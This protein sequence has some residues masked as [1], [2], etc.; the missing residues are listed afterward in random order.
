MW[1]LILRV[2][3]FV[4]IVLFVLA[5]IVYPAFKSNVPFF[6]MFR[7]RRAEK[8]Y[9]KQLDELDNEAMENAVL[10]SIEQRQDN[11]Q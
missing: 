8:K 6:W 3:L 5:N 9:E 4:L 11:K 2:L 10:K 7:L 1:L